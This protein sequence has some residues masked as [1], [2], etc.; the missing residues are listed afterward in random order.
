[1]KYVNFIE[2]L[3]LL[4]FKDENTS[5]GLSVLFTGMLVVFVIHI[6]VMFWLADDQSRH[7]VKSLAICAAIHLVTII[8]VL[9]F[10]IW[11]AWVVGIIFEIVI[12]SSSSYWSEDYPEGLWR[13]HQELLKINLWR[14]E[15]LKI[16]NDEKGRVNY[17]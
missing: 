5:I 13:K 6:L 12:I 2:H 14:K 3:R 9:Q 17:S 7:L 10:N 1:M 8:V 11:A 4:D 15:T 16:L